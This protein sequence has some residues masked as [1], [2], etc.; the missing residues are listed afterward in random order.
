MINLAINGGEKVRKNPFPGY[1]EIGE[2]E[3]NAV[4]DVLRSGKL[5][6]FHSSFYGGE[7]VREFEEEFAKYHNVKY[8]IASN[9]GTAALHIAVAAAGIGPGDEVITT[10]YTFTST[11]TSILM[12]NAI[13][14]FADINPETLCIDPK[15]IRSKITDKTKAIIVVHLLGNIADM[16]EIMSIARERNLRVIEDAAQ[17]IGSKSKGR[18]AGTMGDLATFSFQENKNL[19][20]GEG[21]MTITNDPDLAKRCQLIRNHGED[22]SRE[23]MRSYISTS[24]G[25]NYRMTE[26]E[27]AIGLVQLKKLDKGNEIRKENANFL[28]EEFN[29]I[30]GITPQLIKEGIESTYHLYGIFIDEE[31]L[32]ISRD[33]LVEAL[34]AEGI[35]A[36]KGYS[37]PLYMNPLFLNKTVYGTKGCPFSCKFYDRNIE[38]KAGLCPNIE[39]ACKKTIWFNQV[40]PPAN[41]EDMKDIIDAFKKIIENKNEL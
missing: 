33:K 22:C 16:D 37:H 30:E 13:P 9:S 21:G 26:I 23:E 28:N 14:I 29:K 10:P 18:L 4:N 15:S 38:Y 36:S 11:A 31:K 32:G 5:S 6:T 27:S 40:R 24:L 1:P 19:M 39:K 17:A 35:P 41:L 7:K 3:I 2:E 8:A 34:I 12:H 20:T 25:W